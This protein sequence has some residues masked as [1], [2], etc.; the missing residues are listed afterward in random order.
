MDATPQ[1]AG[2]EIVI[3][4]DSLTQAERLRYFLE[5]NGFAVRSARNGRQALEMV[6]ER[7]PRLVVSDIVMPEVDGYELC[8]RLR[9]DAETADLPVILLTALSESTDVIG[10]LARA[11]PTFSASP[12][13]SSLSWPASGAPSPTASCVA[14]RRRAT[15]WRCCSPAA[16]TRSSRTAPRASTFCC[17]RSKTRSRRTAS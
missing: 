3:A 5:K 10:G 6:A 8:R 14:G 1:G 7:C 4:E 17:R 13:T 16:A 15:G 2:T 12:T 9:Q 11:P